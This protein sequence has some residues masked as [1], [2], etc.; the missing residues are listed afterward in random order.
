[1]PRWLITHR[2]RMIVTIGDRVRALRKEQKMTQADLAAKVSLT[3][4]QIGRYEQQKSQPSGDVVRRLADALGTTAD[5]LMN[6]DSQTVAATRVTDRELLDL[7]AAVEELDQ[8]DQ[9][10]IKTMIDALVTK[11]RVQ[12]LA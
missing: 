9:T 1:M 11:R 3:Y 7:F 6:G 5:Y 4:I 10:M 12:A 2:K 8:Q